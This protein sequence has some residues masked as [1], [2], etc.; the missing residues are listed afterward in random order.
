[1]KELELQLADAKL[2]QVGISALSDLDQ[3]HQL[4]PV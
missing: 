2:K 4:S 1:M 3:T